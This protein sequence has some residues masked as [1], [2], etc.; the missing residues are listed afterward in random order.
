M[1][2]VTFS[3]T[4]AEI[5]AVE[6][7]IT[8]TLTSTFTKI[9]YANRIYYSLFDD[10]CKVC[11][12][13]HHL[14]GLVCLVVSSWP[15]KPT[16]RLQSIFDP[17]DCFNSVITVHKFFTNKNVSANVSALHPRMGCNLYLTCA[18]LN[19]RLPSVGIYRPNVRDLCNGSRPNIPIERA[20]I[21]HPIPW[22]W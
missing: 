10:N 17:F 4:F 14:G 18:Q 21:V 15:L 5:F 19:V 7:S 1:T 13:F 16:T 20:H 2:I 11:L 12:I 3:Q 8:L 6:F 22:Q 9:K